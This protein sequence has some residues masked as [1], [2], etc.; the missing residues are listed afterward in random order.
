MAAAAQGDFVVAFYNPRSRRR[1]DQLQN[2]IAILREHRPPDTPVIVAAHLGRPAESIAVA[3]LAAFDAE[4][5]DMM[6]LVVVG[7]STTAAFTAGDGQQ[8][9]FTPRGYAAKREAAE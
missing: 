8:R 6:S 1:R 9:V 5:V 2:A 4:Q 3:T 7:A